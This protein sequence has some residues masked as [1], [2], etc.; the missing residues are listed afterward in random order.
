MA[1]RR[2]KKIRATFMLVTFASY[3]I[4]SYFITFYVYV[5]D[6]AVDLL[7]LTLAHGIGPLVLEL[8]VEGVPLADVGDMI[9]F[10]LSA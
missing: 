10:K 9:A 4:C 2:P 7:I 3:L 5:Q 6:R 1:C 8:L